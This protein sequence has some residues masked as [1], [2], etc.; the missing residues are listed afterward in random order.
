MD[1]RKDGTGID[2]L[3]L[4]GLTTFCLGSLRLPRT[5][6]FWSLLFFCLFSLLLRRSGESMRQDSSFQARSNPGLVAREERLKREGRQQGG[7]YG[8]E[9]CDPEKL[10]PDYPLAKAD[11]SND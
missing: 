3:L 8:H 10:A 11:A 1:G 2:V 6:S 7:Y 9:Y 5:R 4:D